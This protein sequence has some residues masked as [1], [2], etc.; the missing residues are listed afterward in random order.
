MVVSVGVE[1]LAPVTGVISLVLA[2]M[3]MKKVMQAPVGNEKMQKFGGLIAAGAKTFIKR[4]YKTLFIFVGCFAVLLL[5]VF[6]LTRGFE[7]GLLT[8]VAYLTGSVLSSLAGIVGMGV[9]TKANSRSA[10]AAQKSLN[11]GFK[12]AYSAGSVMGSLVVGFALVGIGALY[13]VATSMF[14]ALYPTGVT[15]FMVAG[16]AKE[17]TAMDLIFEILVGYSFGASSIALFAKAGGGLFTK[18]ADVGADI[19]GKVE[20]NIAE[21]DARNPAAIADAVGDNVGDVAGMGA[22][23]YDSYVASLIAACV[24]GI[25]LDKV[26]GNSLGGIPFVFTLMPLFV[27]GLGNIAAIISSFF[28]KV[29]E[30]EFPGKALNNGTYRTTLIFI[31]L[32]LLTVLVTLGNWAVF[33]SATIGIVAGVIIGVTSDIFTSTDGKRFAP[34]RKVAEAAQTGHATVVLSG[35]AYGLLSIVPSVLGIAIAMLVS[36]WAGTT[37]AINPADSFTTGIYCVAISAVGMLSITAMVVS[38]DAYGPIVDNAAN[39]AENSGISGEA[40]ENCSKM[41]EAGNTAKAIT[42]GFS[43]GAAAL[44][45]IA[46]LAA[47][48][49]LTDTRMLNIL[50]PKIMACLLIGSVIPA[51]FSAMLVMGVGNT[52]EKMIVEIRRQ[53][54]ERPGILAGTEDADY[55]ACIDI[56]TKGAL[57]ELLPPTLIAI[58][59]TIGIGLLFGILGLAGYLAG[60]IVSGLLLALLMSNAGGTWDNAKKYIE[61][62]H[63]GGKGS[64]AH[65]AAVTGDTVGDPFKD[66]A[67]PSMNTL[68]CVMSL[69]ANLFAPVFMIVG[70]GAGL[71]LV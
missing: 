14:G 44:T 36:Y 4:Q 53:F 65:K 17:F 60:S 8:A 10:N 21:D 40:L 15:T 3:A 38:N 64:D 5:V 28:V 39:I 16:V 50:E 43:V 27:A 46:L 52:A 41:D 22:D 34:A 2:Y 25:V 63:F 55:G 20:Q 32:T 26:I 56:A 31:G 67:G 29:K 35:F 9:S 66:T 69:V 54:K 62:G 13:Y 1:L 48:L 6:T 42:K 37:F 33:I 70:G 19:V 23:I 59:A 11:E 45:V 24:L 30:G 61:D 47:F 51:L 49:E 18:A 12:V 57:H 68:I 7:Q 71:L 58:F